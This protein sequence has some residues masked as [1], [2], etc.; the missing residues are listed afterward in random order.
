MWRDA[1]TGALG[2]LCLRVAAV[3]AIA[4]GAE[5]THS[6]GALPWAANALQLAFLAR[7]AGSSN[8]PV[9]RLRALALALA[10]RA[11]EVVAEELGVPNLAAVGDAEFVQQTTEWSVELATLKVTSMMAALETL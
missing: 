9:E 8:A 4:A 6:Y 3:R 5:L 7:R 11:P 1:D 10:Q 2:F